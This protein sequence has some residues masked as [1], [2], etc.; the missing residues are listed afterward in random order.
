MIIKLDQEGLNFFLCSSSD[1]SCIVKAKSEDEAAS[2]ALIFALSELKEKTNV[3]AVMGVKRIEEKFENSD[4]LVRMDQT[5]ADIGMHKES[6]A[7]RE[8]FEK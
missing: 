8:I 1:W 4:F 3:S 2:S 5:L 7:L 6:K